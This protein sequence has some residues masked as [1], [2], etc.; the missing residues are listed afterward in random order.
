MKISK[1]KTVCGL[2]AV[3]MI[4]FG[5]LQE[6]YK[7]N[8]C[9]SA[10]KVQAAEADENGFV[11]EDG[12]LTKYTGKGGEVT[13]PDGITSI[14]HGAFDWY[15]NL[16]EVGIGS[17][18]TSIGDYAFRGCINLKQITLSN[19]LVSIGDFAFE[20]CQSLKQIEIPNNVTSIGKG[21]FQDCDQLRE[22]IIF[23]DHP[24]YA[25][26]D[27]A[28]FNKDMTTLIQYPSEIES[29]K[30]PNS[31]INIGYHAFCNCSSLKR[32][33][34]PDSVVNIG[35][36]AF[37]G[38]SN[39]KQIEVPDGVTKIEDNAFRVCS[40]LEQIEI[41]RSVISIGIDAFSNCSS[42][43]Q[44]EI[45]ES[46][47]SIG[48]WAFSNCSSLKR[49]DIPNSVIDIGPDTFYGVSKDFTIYCT[50]GSYVHTYAKE[51]GL[52][53]IFGTIKPD[54]S[55]KKKKLVLKNGQK[56]KIKFLSKPD[57]LSFKSKDPSIA[58]VNSKGVVTGKKKGKTVITVS[59]D[60]KTAKVKVTIKADSSVIKLSKNF[61]LSKKSVTL[62]KGKK[63]T[64]QKASGLSG[65]VTF[66]SSNAKVASVSVK[67]VVKAKKK[68]KAVILIKRSGK[69]VKLNITVRKK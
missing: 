39:L 58:A 29:Y 45:P 53:Y 48:D 16:T 36:G 32:I 20:F 2:I 1:I 62:K 8:K 47:V 7:W 17:S 33:D 51:K 43:K 38:C 54:W 25:F 40:S 63:L 68:G 56:S 57:N 12:V 52:A 60:G 67:G 42:L 35:D 14:G 28:L 55:L 65:K 41:P 24:N 6:G 31:V 50:E 23:S 15:D 22:I 21:V 18:V 13:I 19:S 4:V 64:I 37:W 61:K 69:T 9:G 26:V 34:I 49:I 5:T 11:I 46:V 66:K 44:I 59:A 3:I 27:G 30:I 10:V